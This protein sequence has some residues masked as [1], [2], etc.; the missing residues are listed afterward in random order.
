MNGTNHTVI[1]R[2]DSGDKM[3]TTVLSDLL[4]LEFGEEIL[5]RLVSDQFT[6]LNNSILEGGYTAYFVKSPREFRGI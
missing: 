2:V 6:N 4:Y 5:L 3:H 1:D